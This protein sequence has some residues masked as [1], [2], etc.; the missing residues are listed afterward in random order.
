MTVA[1]L[2]KSINLGVALV[3]S[4]VAQAMRAIGVFK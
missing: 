3:N 1:M 4:N 2:T